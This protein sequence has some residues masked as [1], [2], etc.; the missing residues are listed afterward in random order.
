MNENRWWLAL[1][2][3]VTVICANG[4][5]AGKAFYEF[6]NDPQQQ[7]TGTFLFDAPGI[8]ETSG[9]SIGAGT[10]L[11]SI[12]SG[13][14]NG[15]IGNF[16]NGFIPAISG[17][18][19][20]TTDFGSNDGSELDFGAIGGGTVLTF[21][22]GSTI[23]NY[24]FNNGVPDVVTIASATLNVPGEFRLVPEPSMLISMAVAAPLLLRRRR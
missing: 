14:L 6:F 23:S 18:L 1:T 19:L 17:D 2:F 22:D 3:A 20:V 16:G 24:D 10:S 7:V 5:H 15:I 4:A 9:W 21:A 8:S 13:G 12:V 11:T